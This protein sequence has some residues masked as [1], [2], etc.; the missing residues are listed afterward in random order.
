MKQKIV[1]NPRACVRVRVEYPQYV[2]GEEIVE[3]SAFLFRCSHANFGAGIRHRYHSFPLR[4]E[5]ALPTIIQG[6]SVWRKSFAPFRGSEYSRF[7]PV[8][9]GLF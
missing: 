1:L 8:F 9:T 3:G 5:A 6:P 7:P 4:R 2:G